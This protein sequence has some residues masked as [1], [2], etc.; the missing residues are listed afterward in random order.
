[1]AESG[2]ADTQSPPLA[3]LALDAGDSGFIERWVRGS[4]L[5]TVASIMKR[6][7]WGRIVGPEHTCEHGK[8]LSALILLPMVAHFHIAKRGSPATGSALVAGLLLAAAWVGALG[9]ARLLS[10]PTPWD[11]LFKTGQVSIWA[12]VAVFLLDQA[13]WDTKAR[14]HC[15]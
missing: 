6:G 10:G 13:R 4:Y 7:C 11:S 5:P 12:A 3:I 15:E 14:Q 8:W 1:V 2:A 9:P